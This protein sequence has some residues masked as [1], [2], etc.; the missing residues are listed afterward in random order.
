MAI[1]RPIENSR[2]GEYFSEFRETYYMP[3]AV[4]ANQYPDD[5]S[6]LLNIL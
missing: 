3:N 6:Y 4:L 5:V 1:P 2:I